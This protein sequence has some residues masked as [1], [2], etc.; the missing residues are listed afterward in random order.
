MIRPVKRAIRV[1]HEEGLRRVAAKTPRYVK[2]RIRR[3]WDQIIRPYLPRKAVCYNGVRVRAARWFDS[4]LPWYTAGRPKYE[5]GLLHEIRKSVKHGNSI[6]IV[7]GGW[8]VSSVVAARQTGE[9]GSVDVYEGSEFA[10][11]Q[12]KETIGLNRVADQVIVHHA[13]VGPEVQLD[14]S[15]GGAAGVT[16]GDLPE[17]DVLVLDCEGAETAILSNLEIDPQTIIVETHGLYDSPEE[18]VRMI[19]ESLEYEITD[20]KVAEVETVNRLVG[21]RKAITSLGQ[22]C[23]ENG[24]FV[25]VANNLCK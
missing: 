12:V 14:G 25:L 2:R 23:M 18:D 8:G 20:R 17:C 10:V 19:L 16:P 1:Y 4:S 22:A 21:G 9:V 7:G 3:T 5:V 24:V 11:K 15:R 13:V 6:A